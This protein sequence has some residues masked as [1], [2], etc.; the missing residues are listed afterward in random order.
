MWMYYHAYVIKYKSQSKTQI[1]M[2][3]LSDSI[4]VAL[5]QCVFV[6]G[7]L[8]LVTGYIVIGLCK[9]TLSVIYGH[10]RAVPAIHW[11]IDGD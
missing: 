7:Y 6:M 9:D 8:H 10:H 5:Q 11:V 4:N 2:A 3:L 1:T